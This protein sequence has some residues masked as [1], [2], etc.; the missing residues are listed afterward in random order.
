MILRREYN[1]GAAGC[2]LASIGDKFV[3][4]IK[5]QTGAIID[6]PFDHA[7]EIADAI[8]RW[9]LDRRNLAQEAA[10]PEK[11]GET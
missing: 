9:E 10:R 5:D 4:C 7:I 11:D 2:C 6:L 1:I 8:G 3:V